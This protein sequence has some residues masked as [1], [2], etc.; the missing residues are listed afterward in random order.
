MYISRHFDKKAYV[1]NLNYTGR[2]TESELY[3]MFR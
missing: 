1:D 3:I 2:Y